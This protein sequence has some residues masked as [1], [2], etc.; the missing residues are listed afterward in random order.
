MLHQC[1]HQYYSH[2]KLIAVGLMLARAFLIVAK[3]NKKLPDKN[4]RAE[5]LF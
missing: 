1:V 2:R 4:K 5:A 3:S